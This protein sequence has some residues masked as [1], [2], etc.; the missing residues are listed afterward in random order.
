MID[1]TPIINA[2]IVILAAIAVRYVVPWI[3]ENTDAKERENLL[4]WAE[5]AVYAAQQL[6]YQKDGAYRLEYALEVL[7][8]KGFDI[9]DAAVRDAVEAAVLKLH[10]EL[11]MV[12]E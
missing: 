2:V 9:D 6:Y 10:S 11:V 4:K 5:I 1:L 12:D 8:G 3:I 7:E